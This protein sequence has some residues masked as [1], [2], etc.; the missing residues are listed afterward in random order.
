MPR[1]GTRSSSRAALDPCRLWCISLLFLLIS[2]A[3]SYWCLLMEL[4]ASAETGVQ[5]SPAAPRDSQEKCLVLQGFLFFLTALLLSLPS[6]KH[7]NFP[8]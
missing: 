8:T 5:E 4:V 6:G 1:V 2:A 7:S 3:H